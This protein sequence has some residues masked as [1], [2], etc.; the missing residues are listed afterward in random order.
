MITNTT[1]LGDL[2]FLPSHGFLIIMGNGV[3]KGEWQG[4][5]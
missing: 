5:P 3:S 2:H 1:K 4:H